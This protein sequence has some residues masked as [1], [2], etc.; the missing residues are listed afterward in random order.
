MRE[1]RGRDIGGFT[2]LALAL[3]ALGAWFLLGSEPGS[4]AMA[5][6]EAG[7]VIGLAVAGGAAIE[8][9]HAQAEAVEAPAAKQAPEAGMPD[10]PSRPAPMPAASDTL[11]TAPIAAPSVS[12]PASMPAPATSAPLAPVAALAPA[13]TELPQPISPTAAPVTAAALSLP[14]EQTPEAASAPAAPSL[15]D[16]AP[17]GSVAPE[18]AAAPDP[19]PASPQPEQAEAS[20]QDA[21]DATSIDNGPVSPV[22]I[23]RPVRVTQPAPDKKEAPAASRAAGNRPAAA[24]PIAPAS[25]AQSA[26]QAPP[27]RALPSG[28]QADIAGGGSPGARQDFE[29]L[30]AA[31]LAR[32]RQ[33]PRA[34]RLRRQQGT[35]VLAFVMDAS[36]RVLDAELRRSA[37]HAALDAEILD[38]VRRAEPLPQ[39][40]PALGL[41]RME[42]VVPIAFALR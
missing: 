31:T 16:P 1:L 9:V 42:F 10:A 36:G 24:S 15:S 7:L 40:P 32:H 20:T 21:R 23:Q 12:P 17:A 13:P 22:P 4:G 2:I 19:L 14:P 39:I 8:A 5:P 37:G 28:S 3:H 11:E 26:S 6:G 38:L 33:Y 29:A 35:G 34:A 41:A 30:V 25:V 27:G 18:P